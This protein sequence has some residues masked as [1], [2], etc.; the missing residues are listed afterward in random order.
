MDKLRGVTHITKRFKKLLIFMLVPVSLVAQITVLAKPVDEVATIQQQA[1][2][3]AQKIVIKNAKKP[4]FVETINQDYQLAYNTEYDA[5]HYQFMMGVQKAQREFETHEKYQLEDEFERAGYKYELERVKNA[6]GDSNRLA[7]HQQAFSE[8]SPIKK[9]ERVIQNNT[10]QNDVQ[11]CPKILNDV[12]Q[13]DQPILDKPVPAP[14]DRK[15]V[16]QPLPK[17]PVNLDHLS[18]INQFA[19]QAAQV[20]AENDLFASVMIA[21]AALE[22]SWGASELAQRPNYNLF[23]VK[24][25]YKGQTISMKTKEDVGGGKCI[26]IRDDFRKYPNYRA[27]LNDYVAVLSQEQ[28][29]LAKKSQCENYHACTKFLTG[30]YATDTS[31]NLKLDQIIDS[32][33]LTQYDQS[34]IAIDTKRPRHRHNSEKSTAK[35]LIKKSKPKSNYKVLWTDLTSCTGVILGLIVAVRKRLCS[36]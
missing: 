26:E 34:V 23:G 31:Y 33:N 13:T 6:P 19:K 22:S 32:Y 12:S 2:E 3:D 9:C 35:Q 20:A 15:T 30:R 25:G 4:I 16:I 24:G 28:F 18:F 14:D 29:R 17:V 11:L 8:K 27:S 1:I 36:K 5:C 7:E 10:Q 21:Q